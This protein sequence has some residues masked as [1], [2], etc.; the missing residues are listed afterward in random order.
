LLEQRKKRPTIVYP[1]QL[2]LIK[3]NH[4]QAWQMPGMDEVLSG[5]FLG[6]MQFPSFF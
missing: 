4:R 5:W 3:I 1:P 6:T 2:S